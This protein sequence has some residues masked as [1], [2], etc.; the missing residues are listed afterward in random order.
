[1]LSDRLV[2]EPVRILD[3]ERRDVTPKGLRWSVEEGQ[4]GTWSLALD[5]DDRELPLPYVI[6]PAIAAR[7]PASSA[8]TG[9]GANT[10]TITK[11][12]GLVA[13]DLMLAQ[14]TTRGGTNIAICPPTVTGTWT[15]VN[16][17]NS[18]TTLGQEVFRLSATAADVAAASY[19]FQLRTTHLRRRA[20]PTPR[21]RAAASSRTSTRP[22]RRTRSTPSAGQAFALGERP[23]RRPPSHRRSP[24]PASPPSTALRTAA[25]SATNW[26]G[27]DGG[28][29]GSVL[30]RRRRRVAHDVGGGRRGRVRGRRARHAVDR[31]LDVAP[32]R[33]NIGQTLA[34]APLAADGSG[35][36]TTPTTN[37]AAGSTGNTL[38]FTYTAATGGMRNGSVTLV[39]PTGWSAPSTTGTAA[40]YTTSSTGTVGVAG[41][42]ITVSGVT[43][44]ATS[45]LTVVYGSTAGTGPGATA[46]ATTGAQTWQAQQR[47]SSVSGAL[48]NLGSSPSVTV[49]AADGSG[50]LTTPTTNVP[51]G[52]TGNTLTF[53]YTAADRRD[54]E[55]R[56][57]RHRADRLERTVDHRHRGRLHDRQHRHRRRRRP[58]RSPSPASPSPAAPP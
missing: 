14:I 50:T 37:V 7:T 20:S 56:R 53:T 57:P 52:S 39:V 25:R 46:T 27:V 2:L 41:Q 45:T 26:T 12:A 19:A 54:G 1:M 47:S 29:V 22:T 36:L 17:T 9:G 18:T 11:P 6:D 5:L 33:V 8:N 42:T 55:R 40:G 43:L 30:D 23:S 10:I 35:T 58:G 51:A 28:A 16:R 21:R 48:V 34:L 4:D 31:R 13:G 49:N 15:S 3:D 32:T 44:T 24:T 38:T